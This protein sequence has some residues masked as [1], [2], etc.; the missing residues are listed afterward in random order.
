MNAPS[1][2][3]LTD[4]G[5]CDGFRTPARSLSAR[6]ARRLVGRRSK[7]A[8]ERNRG[9]GS[10]PI[11]GRYGNLDCTVRAARQVPVPIVGARA[12]GISPL[13]VGAARPASV[14]IVG[15]RDGLRVRS[16]SSFRGL[17]ADCVA[18]GLQERWRGGALSPGDVSSGEKGMIEAEVRRVMRS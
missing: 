14:A 6:H 13:R 11:R 10:T 7:A 5:F 1:D 12:M 18:D 2:L 16:P 9:W 4:G 17:S 8:N 3:R 15:A